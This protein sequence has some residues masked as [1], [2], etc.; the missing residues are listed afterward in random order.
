MLQTRSVLRDGVIHPPTGLE[1]IVA[2]HCNITCRQCNH[3]SPAIGKWYVS[4]EDIG[5]DLAMLARHYQPAFLKYIG[6]EPLLHPDLPGILRAGR[7]SGI[8]SHHMLVTNGMLLDRMP[9]EAWPLLDEIEVSHYPAAGLSES[10]LARHRATA[11]AH[12]VRFT[13]NAHAEFRR[14]FTR[15]RNDD[16]AL[17][18][19]I[20]KACKP[21]NVW[22]CHGIYK[23]AIYRC[24]QSI[25]APRLAG[26]E[27]FDGFVL[28]ESADFAARLLAF[29]NAQQP[30]ASCRYCVG[31]VGK[32]EPHILLGRKVW[33][34]DLD[35]PASEMIDARLLAES[36]E[37][38]VLVDDCKTPEHR[39][40]KAGRLQRFLARLH[41]RPK[42]LRKATHRRPGP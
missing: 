39:M 20:F 30:L 4:P 41:Y 28:A 16:D 34:A 22:G 9:A 3:G 14:T 38:F 8:A 31:T 32:K 21:A 2:D 25:Y 18:E 33:S 42:R 15:I 17:V 11:K 24:P 7:A 5:R 35:I 6:G 13:L 29:L 1:I 12:G 26:T 37:N 19:K 23:G 36:L 10:D 27:D 40:K